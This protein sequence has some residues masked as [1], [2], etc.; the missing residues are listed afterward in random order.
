MFAIPSIL[1]RLLRGAE[2]ASGQTPK[3][4]ATAYKSTVN[5][6]PRDTL[7][8]KAANIITRLKRPPAYLNDEAFN[9]FLRTTE[10]NDTLYVKMLN[11][12]KSR[13][14]SNRKS[15]RENLYDIW[16]ERGEHFKD[17][18]IK[19][20]K[21]KKNP[22]H[23]NTITREARANLVAFSGFA[24]FLLYF[25]IIG[26][27][28]ARPYLIELCIIINAALFISYAL[29]FKI[30]RGPGASENQ[31]SWI[32]KQLAM[33]LFVGAF[34]GL[35]LGA[36]IIAFFPQYHDI[37]NDGYGGMLNLLKIFWRDLMFY[38]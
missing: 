23:D 19:T 28:D 26:E 3:K 29:R 8:T 34:A 30:G 15:L 25:A 17:I 22:H 20:E 36:Y 2:G 4:G 31:V 18:D 21:A 6:T 11:E 35:F 1:L 14:R 7:I 10:T 9:V 16:S 13:G 24:N 32:L 27:A 5:I 12:A 38:N 37:T 33:P